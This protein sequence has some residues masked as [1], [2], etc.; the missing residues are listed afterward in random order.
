MAP[1]LALGRTVDVDPRTD[2]WAVGATLFTLLSGKLVHD[3]DSSAEALVR[4]ATR[5][6]PALAS[7]AP[8]VPPALAA[9]VDRALA[10]DRDARW[11]TARAMADALAAAHGGSP[12]KGVLAALVPPRSAT[13]LREVARAGSSSIASA[14][15]LEASEAKLL[16]D[17]SGGFPNAVASAPTLPANQTGMPV[18][19]TPAVR[20]RAR[21][22][23][24]IGLTAAMGVADAGATWRATFEVPRRPPRRRRSL[25]RPSKAPSSSSR[26][27]RIAR[28]IPSSTGSSI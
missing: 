17:R 3:V 28:P 6:A 15:T 7:V 19:T 24:R 16:A 27:S 8:T 5:P 2:V 26:A 4:A 20:R 1:E 14:P 10:F 23:G 22:W 9:V 25:R 11:P 13:S 21:G 18:A 12:P